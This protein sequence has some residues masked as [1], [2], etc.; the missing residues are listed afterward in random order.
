MNSRRIATAPGIELDVI[1][2]GPADG[3]VIVLC[4]G[5][6]ESS[7]SWRHQ[8]EPLAADG[9]RVLV[10]DQRGYSTSSA[11]REVSEYRSE[12]LAADLVALLDDVGAETAT[13]VGHD[14]GA[15]VVWDLARLHP[16]RV[17]AVVNVSVPYMPWPMQP[18]ELFQATYGDRFF[19]MLY[20]QPV[21]P[22]EAE[23]DA[24]IARSLRTVIWGGAGEMARPPSGP[25][26]LP[27]L[28]GT[29]LLDVW[30]GEGAPDHL[31]PW[32]AEADFDRYVEQFTASGF[33]GPISWYR[34]LDTNWEM[35]RDLPAPPMPCAFIGGSRDMVIA[36]RMEYVHAMKS[37][38]PDYR[39]TFMIDGPGHW[40]QQEAPDAF[41]V[42]LNDAL[43][44]CAVPHQR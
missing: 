14:W 27:P 40:T 2:A 7:H 26:D 4:H 32:L 35:T 41:N 8:I 19:Y 28:E 17:N 13:F 42:A 37:S 24:D 16:D 33:F 43:K 39:G 3:P 36:H 23:L 10:P 21:G 20:F 15:L 5:W 22:A 11:P 29:G 18:T 6:P 34:N 25:E 31:P 1:D 38:L 9:W 30:A 12:L 44:A